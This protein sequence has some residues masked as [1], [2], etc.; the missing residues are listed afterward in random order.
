MDYV[1]KRA[2]RLGSCERCG[3]TVLRRVWHYGEER[4]FCGACSTSTT[5]DKVYYAPY[6]TDDLRIMRAVMW[7][8][9]KTRSGVSRRDIAAHLGITK[10]PRLLTLLDKL[11]STGVLLKWQ[12]VSPYNGRTQILYAPWVDDED[13]RNGRIDAVLG[14]K[15][16]KAP[17]PPW[18]RGKRA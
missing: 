14:T 9:S 3:S 17:V 18:K 6:K 10:N 12:G 7:L 5:P 13:E 15:G 4:A 8:N 1:Y 16:I 2:G 11:V